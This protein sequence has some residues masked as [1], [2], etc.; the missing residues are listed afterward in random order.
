MGSAVKTVGDFVSG[1][2]KDAGIG[3]GQYKAEKVDINSDAFKNQNADARQTQFAGALATTQGR[4][5]PT[6]KAAVLPGST[7]T[8]AAKINQGPQ[9]Q[10]RTGQTTLMSQLAAQ[11]AGKGPS[12]AQSQLAQA[13]DRNLA[14]SMALAGS[15]RG[16]SAGSGMRQIAQGQAQMNQQAAQQSADL[17]MN[18]QMAARQ[19]LGGVMAQGREQD[20]GLATSQAG[21]TQQA[22][23]AN[24]DAANQFK[25]QQAGFNQQAAGNNQQAALAMQG[26][27]DDQ[28]K[29]LMSGQ[30]A[31]DA[32]GMEGAMALEKLKVQQSLGVAG[33]NQAAYADAS[34][35]RQGFIGGMGEGAASA[36]AMMSDERVKTNIADGEDETDEFLKN[37]SSALGKSKQPAKEESSSKQMG[38]GVMKMAGM[39]AMAM[40]D[41]KAK[42]ET[43]GA[44]PKLKE[45]LNALG[46]HSYK[47]KD[48]KHGVGT[49]VSPMAQEL[50][51][52][53]LGRSMVVETPEGKA[54]NYAKAGG[55]M[56]ATAAMLNDRVGS[57]E[58]RLAKAF[59][60]DKKGRAA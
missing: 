60:A 7:Q 43:D 10:F 29:A 16:S 19:Q 39:A 1:T 3:L 30:L 15:Q 54:V 24:Q 14:Q 27:N 5:G 52:S 51:K 17:R 55:L 13:T 50:E 58:E 23:L 34:K 31:M 8:Q 45:F 9:D 21:F 44:D 26:M 41:K 25:L 49:H 56:L 32:Q 38:Q 18:E 2:S 57:M 46:T 33:V 35:N 20:I 36:A 53:E 12:L 22:K 37:F 11:A 48:Q 28:A 59:A 40:S 47:Y 6:M 4:Q 42:N